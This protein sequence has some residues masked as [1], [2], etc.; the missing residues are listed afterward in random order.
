MKK[1][2]HNFILFSLFALVCAAAAIYYLPGV[3]FFADK[4]ANGL[5]KE[6]L[7]R[8]FTAAFAV[9]AAASTKSK[10][11]LL[12]KIKRLPKNLL[13]I[14]PCIAVAVV[15]FPFSAL[16]GGKATVER[17]DLIPLLLINCLSIAVLEETIFRALLW[18]FFADKL[19]NSRY[20]LF[21]TAITT[22]ALFGVWHLLN[23]FSGAAIG[24]TILQVL[25]TFLLG[26]AFS[27][28]IASTG[29][30]W[31]PVALHAVFDFGGSLVYRLGS[32]EFQDAAF[33][34][35]T[36]TVGALCA[37]YVIIGFVRLQKKDMA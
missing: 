27:F 19:K 12:P 26:A 31:L 36:L 23:L 4:T 22:S 32:G 16:I 8:F 10:D 17:Y 3:R 14:L 7:L 18:R 13:I 15:N 5:F 35:L 9:F 6:V 37:I 30:L 11:L 29:D 20:N 25:Y 21:L 33:W 28:V 24:S 1:I 34:I 2:T